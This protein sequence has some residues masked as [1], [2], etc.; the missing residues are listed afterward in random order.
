M[1]YLGQEYLL[2]HVTHTAWLSWIWA[3]QVLY[4]ES[5]LLGEVRIYNEVCQSVIIDVL[6][7]C[8]YV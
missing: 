3:T 2:F 4:C 7:A 8:T 6:S 5:E 1:K